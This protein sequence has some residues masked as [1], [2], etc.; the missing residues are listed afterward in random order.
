MARLRRLRPQQ[1]RPAPRHR[2]GAPLRRF[3]RPQ[4]HP[5]DARGPR[6]AQRP[7]ARRRRTAARALAR[8]RRSRRDPRLRPPAARSIS[9]NT[10]ASRRRRRRSPT[11]S[12]ITRTTSTTACAPACSI[13]T[14]SAPSRSSPRCSTRSSAC[15]PASSGRASS[16]NC[17]A[18]SS[19]ASS[20]T[21][22]PR[23]GARIAAAGVDEPR[24]RA[25]GGPR[26]WSAFRRRSATAERDI[27]AF[28]FAHMYRHP[29]STRVREQADAIVR[30]LFSAYLADARGDAARLGGQGRRDR[31][32]RARAAADYIAGMTDRFALNEYRRLFDPDGE[33][34]IK[35]RRLRSQAQFMNIFADFQA[36]V[37]AALESW[38]RRGALPAE[39]RPHALRRRAAAR[40]RARRSLDQRR[41]GLRARGQGGRLAIRARWPRRW[42]RSCAR[43]RT[44][45]RS[46]SP[47]PASS[48]SA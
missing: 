4:P 43:R 24:G 35:P 11:T 10:P 2:A 27:K 36:R 12:P 20:R 1:P 31:G 38:R 33:L 45:R 29:R 30:A 19:P 18:A 41:D 9:P 39:P 13:S 32:E 6:Q 44:S 34:A 14:R 47:A 26:R 40:G 16:T 3:R 28:L 21:P 37:G 7:A 17:R 46:R 25:R 15:I 48:T 5:G 42:P 8:A 23:R 22:S